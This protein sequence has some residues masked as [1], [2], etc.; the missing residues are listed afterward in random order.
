[1]TEQVVTLSPGESKVVSFEAVPKEAKTYLVSVNGLTGSFRATTPPTIPQ[2]VFCG[3]WSFSD[4]PYERPEF[5]VFYDGLLEWQLLV[6]NQW[7]LPANKECSIY[8]KARNTGNTAAEF[9]VGR[10]LPQ[11]NA[12]APYSEQKV[13]L[14]PGE[15]SGFFDLHF[16]LPSPGAYV[17]VFRLYADGQIVD[18][19]QKTVTTF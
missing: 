18:E 11:F 9:M 14:A 10:Y 17:W 13:S 16:N 2:G 6:G 3:R 4:P 8:I 12:V 5:W 1:M 15:R 19:I 7:N